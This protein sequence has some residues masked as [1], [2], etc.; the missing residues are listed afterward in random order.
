MKSAGR[1]FRTSGCTSEESFRAWKMKLVSVHLYG[2][3][4]EEEA[5]RQVLKMAGCTADV[6]AAYCV[7]PNSF[8]SWNQMCNIYTKQLHRALPPHS[9]SIT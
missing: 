8:Q 9:M 1:G 3:E 4:K 7:A 5:K 6:A 2:S